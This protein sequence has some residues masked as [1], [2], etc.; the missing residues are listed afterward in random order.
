[1]HGLKS[2]IWAFLKIAKMALFNPKTCRLRQDIGYGYGVFSFNFHQ[3]FSNFFWWKLFDVSFYQIFFFLKLRMIEIGTRGR[4]KRSFFFHKI[5]ALESILFWLGCNVWKM[6]D[7]FQRPLWPISIIWWKLTTNSFHQKKIWEVLMKIEGIQAISI[8]G[9][10]FW[11]FRVKSFE[12]I[13]WSHYAWQ[14]QWYVRN[15]CAFDGC[16]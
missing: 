10:H 4:W 8:L 13:S 14:F 2:A 7:L 11:T 5:K 9:G 3:N 15:N 1:M 12:H 6:D 16:V